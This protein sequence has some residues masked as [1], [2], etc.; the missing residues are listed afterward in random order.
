MQIFSKWLFMIT[1]KKFLFENSKNWLLK[2]SMKVLKLLGN[3]KEIQCTLNNDKEKEFAMIPYVLR[4]STVLRSLMITWHRTSIARS[5]LSHTMVIKIIYLTI[6]RVWKL[7]V[8][9]GY[10]TINYANILKVIV[11]DN[12][13]E[14]FIWE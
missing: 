2:S 9:V 8:W 6:I 4:H 12:C 3:C 14:I 13:K 5:M 7:Y 10:T 11:H 1:A